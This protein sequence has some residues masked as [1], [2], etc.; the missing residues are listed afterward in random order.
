MKGAIKRAKAPKRSI[1]NHK[2]ANWTTINYELRN[3]NWAHHID[4]TDVNTAWL[5]FKSILNSICDAHIPKVTIKNKLSYPWY[6][7]EVHKLNRKKEKYRSQY[8]TSQNAIHYS[9]YSQTRKELKNLKSKMRDNLF[10]DSKPSSLTKK[11]LVLCKM[12]L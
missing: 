4:Y 12:L 7:A 10:D 5:N 3:V 11:I 9:K 2:K 1:R 8:K 6:D